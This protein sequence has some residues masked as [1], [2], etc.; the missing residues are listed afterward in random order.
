M[1]NN[2]F[3]A[4]GAALVLAVGFSGCSN[5]SPGENAGV[6]GGLTAVAV[7]VPLAAAGVDPAIG[8]PITL[9]A[10][11]LAATTAYIYAKHQADENQR[12]IAEARAR[13]YLAEQA[14]QQR[15]D[16]AEA[17]RAA[18]QRVSKK[19]TPPRYIAVETD[20]GG[21]YKGKSAVMIYDTK[22]EQL[23]GNNVYD[24]KS[25][26]KTGTVS[27]YDTVQAEYVGKGV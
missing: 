22:S 14:K 5:L 12:R 27:K 15:E 1:N 23:V 13:L 3:K 17:A 2:P 24:L 9:G 4:A 21:D 11:A 19:K 8:I 6:F 16:E 25:A 18:N 20:R 7:G 26:P 10:A